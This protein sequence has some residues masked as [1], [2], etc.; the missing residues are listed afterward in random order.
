LRLLALDTGTAA[1]Y[2]GMAHLPPD[3]GTPTET[4]TLWLRSGDGGAQASLSLI[5]AVLDVLAQAQTPLAG[6]DALVFGRGPGSFTGLRTACAV[7]QGLAYGARSDAH[8]QGLPVLGIDSLMAVAEDARHAWHTANAPVPGTPLTITALLDARMDEV[9]TATYTFADATQPQATL[10]GGPWL[11]KPEQVEGLLAPVEHPHLLAGN[12]FEA[13]G[14]R[15]PTHLPRL[16]AAPTAAALLR[17]AP[18]LLAQGLAGGPA[19]AQPLYV[20]DKVA[21]TTAEREA[22]RQAPHP[23]GSAA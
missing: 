2:V 3:G 12:A 21:Q 16:T 22:A 14:P 5:P 23:T 1:Q 19:D 9:Y 10:A 6:L 8:P 15:L 18:A 17:L 20:R 11:L 4:P 7:V 13:Y